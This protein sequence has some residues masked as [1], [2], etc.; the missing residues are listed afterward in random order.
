MARVLLIDDDPYVRESTK[1][2]L[3][4][5]GHEVVD[6]DDPEQVISLIEKGKPD[7]IICDFNMDGKNGFEVWESIK[8]I[9]SK[10]YFFI[11]TGGPGSDQKNKDDLKTAQE[12]GLTILW[13]PISFFNLKEIIEKAL[14]HKVS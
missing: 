9:F 8:N 12:I 6:T 5:M 14:N 13:K 11:L 2:I 10:N 1:N 7:L 4:A 3:E